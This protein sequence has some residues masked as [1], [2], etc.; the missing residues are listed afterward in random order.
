[1][2]L[3]RYHDAED[4]GPEPDTPPADEDQADDA[5]PPTRAAGRSAAQSKKGD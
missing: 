5:P 2:L 4:T 1:M 3:R